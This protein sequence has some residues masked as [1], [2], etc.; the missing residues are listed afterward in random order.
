MK[1]PIAN[2]YY[3]LCYAWRHSHESG[4][5]D[6]AELGRFDQVHDLFGK[7]LSEGTFRLLRQGLDRGYVEVSED[8]AGVRGRVDVSETV[9]RGVRRRGRAACRYGELSYDVPHNRILR[10]ALYELLKLEELAPE[11]RTEVGLA[12]R[13]LTDVPLVPFDRGLFRRLQLDRNRHL[14]HFLIA[15][16]WL[17]REGILVDQTTGKSRFRDFRRDEATMWKLFEAFVTEFYAREGMGFDV[18]GQGRIPWH[19]AWSPVAE[20]LEH[21]PAMWADVL[22]ESPD[23]RIILDAKFY[24]RALDERFGT[25]KLRSSNLYQL[26]AYLR[27]RQAARPEG[28]R[29][30]GVLLYPV[31]DSPLAVEVYLEGFRIRARGI[32]LAQDWPLIHRDMLAV[33]QN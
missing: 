25:Q 29:H 24:Q 22:L 18:K 16:C 6:L 33:L 19:A 7:V 32:N 13:R 2:V 21:L 31:V 10:A 9:K 30:E 1:I 8:V 23:R 20:H 14:Y 5:V 26:L 27:N 11:I 28:P 17:I 15:V 3:L 12:Y 4:V